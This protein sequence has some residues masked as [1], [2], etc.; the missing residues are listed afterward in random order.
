MESRIDEI[1]DGIYRI[2]THVAE[3]APPAGFSF[4]QFL[5][6][7]D[8]PLLF[9]TG[10]RR[11]FPLVSAAV[12]RVM[13]LDRLRWVSF[14][15]YEA[16]ECGA[17]NDWL[18]AAPGAQ[19]AHGQLGCMVSLND[20]ADRP[21]RMLADDEEIA[22]GRHRVR[23]LETPHTPHGWDAGVMYEA[24]TGTLF[25][26]DLFSHIGDGPPVT[27]GDVVGPAAAAEDAFRSSSLHPSM[28]RTI[29]RLAGLAPTTLAI[30][31]GSSFAGD[32]AGALE[33]LAADY[34]R[35]I[36]AAA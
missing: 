2:S 15:H 35:R 21:P 33:A 19:V 28:G 25:C 5:V 14:S 9:H 23:Y 36:A 18:A 10:P 7:D 4:N 17:M 20:A 32:G 11:M 31:H 1:A 6:L 12:G 13:P 27:E 16:D 26:S 29:R 22:L 24:T 30:M 34:E 3:I 8:E